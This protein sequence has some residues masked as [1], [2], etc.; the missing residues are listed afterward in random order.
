M[1]RYELNDLDTFDYKLKQTRK[2]FKELILQKEHENE[3]LMLDILQLIVSRKE[4]KTKL[5]ASKVKAYL[6]LKEGDES[7]QGG[8]KNY[9]DWLNE[10]AN[11]LLK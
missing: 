8:L 10:K 9:K 3:K 5:L 11:V 2:D 6:L 4:K 7:E 1:T